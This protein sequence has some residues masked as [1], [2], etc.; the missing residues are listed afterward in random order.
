MTDDMQ[1]RFDR[2]TLNFERLRAEK[3]RVEN[4]LSKVKRDFKTAQWIIKTLQN[5]LG[6]EKAQSAI[7]EANRYFKTRQA[8]DDAED[9]RSRYEKD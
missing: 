8:E 1:D 5:A 4:E 7:T 3:A 6:E 9:L 2:L